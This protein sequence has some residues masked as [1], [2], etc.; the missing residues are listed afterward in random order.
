[1]LVH[2]YRQNLFFLHTHKISLEEYKK[3]LVVCGEG[4]EW[5]GGWVRRVV[6]IPFRLIIYLFIGCGCACGIWHF[7]VAV[8]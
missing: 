3:E 1:M 4:Y 2:M 8:T 6:T 5:L 7:P